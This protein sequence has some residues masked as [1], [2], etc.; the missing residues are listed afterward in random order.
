M[1][2]LNS[3]G[4]E[5]PRMRGAKR[6]R[7]LSTGAAGS[8]DRGKALRAKLL[9]RLA[10]T[11]WSFACSMHFRVPLK[12]VLRYVACS[13]SSAGQFA[14]FGHGIAMGPK[15]HWAMRLVHRNPIDLQ[16]RLS[17]TIGP[18]YFKNFVLAVEEVFFHE[19]V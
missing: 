1:G 19:S 13:R 16:R 7:L 12:L 2:T 14:T 15:S 11:K 3:C 17:S 9:T 18:G 5:R 10:G 4:R 6:T 8:S